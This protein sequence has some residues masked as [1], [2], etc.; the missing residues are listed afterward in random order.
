MPFSFNEAQTAIL[1]RY[2]DQRRYLFKNGRLPKRTSMSVAV[3]CAEVGPFVSSQII[4]RHFANR[5]AAEEGR[6]RAHRK[7]PRQFELLGNSFEDD[8][9]PSTGELILL[10]HESGL[11]PQQVKSWFDG[12]RQK[13]SKKGELLTTRNREND[14]D[15]N[16][17]AKMWRAFKKDPGSY[18]KALCRG[19]ISPVT[20]KAQEVELDEEE[21][22]EESEVDEE[23][24]AKGGD[25]TNQQSEELMYGPEESREE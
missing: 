14:P 15:S 6:P 17:S 20:G 13:A 10:V 3:Q 25:D 11:K 12:Q 16:D 21:G 5:V 4:G 8:P 9:F 23:G 22:D 2:W 18:C 1:D 24:E 19:E 7:T